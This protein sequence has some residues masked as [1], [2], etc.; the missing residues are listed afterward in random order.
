MGN[1]STWQKFQVALSVLKNPFMLLLDKVGMVKDPIYKT[2]ATD[3]RSSME[4]MTRGRTTDINDAVVVLSGKEYPPELI[5]LTMSKQESGESQPV[6]MDC[7]GHIGSFTMYIKSYWPNAKILALEP[8]PENLELY[9]AN[10][11]RNHLADVS[12]IPYAVY[13]ESGTFY[14]DLS[15]KQMDAVHIT[16][17]KPTHNLFIEVQAK[18]LDE[19][20]QDANISVVDLMKLDIEGAEYHLFQHSVQ[21]LNA[22]VRRIIMEFHPAG[23]LA[24]RN[25]IVE[26]LCGEG[27]S[28][29]LVYETKNILGF[30]NSKL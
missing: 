16:S 11:K 26:A 3:K 18:T 7:G 12:V 1:R 27:G 13:G 30:Q 2:R 14:I 29:E 10:I 5:G 20:L 6:V 24:K 15:N 19:I 17:E 25:E 28:F 23:N 9:E 4:F 22:H 21:S 8:V